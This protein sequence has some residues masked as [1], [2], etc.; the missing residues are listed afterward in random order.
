ME[1]AE[2]RMAVLGQSPQQQHPLLKTITNGNVNPRIVSSLT[3]KPWNF[4]VTAL[5][6]RKRR[7]GYGCNNPPNPPINARLPNATLLEAINELDE[8]DREKDGRDAKRQRTG[9]LSEVIRLPGKNQEEWREEALMNLK[10]VVFATNT[11][12]PPV[13]AEDSYPTSPTS[14]AGPNPITAGLL[15]AGGS[16]RK[17]S[18]TGDA[19]RVG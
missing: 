8:L 3:A 14:P 9:S 6:G 2:R 10:T 13:S 1:Y 15:T 4:T 17:D 19:V 5:A 16:S 18:I 11:V 7:R 12:P